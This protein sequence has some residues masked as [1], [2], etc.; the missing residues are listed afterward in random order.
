MLNF[1][2]V[3]DDDISAELLEECIFKYMKENDMPY[4]ITRF[5]EAVT[6]LSLY[7]RDFDIIFMDIM[8]PHMDGMEASKRLREVDPSVVLIFVTDMANYALCGYEVNAQD[9]IVK[10]VTYVDF[11]LKMSRALDQVNRVKGESLVIT[12]QKGMEVILINDLLYVEVLKHKV[13]YHLVNRQV[14]AYGALSKI[15]SKLDNKGF[16]KCSNS[17]IVNLKYITGICEGSEVVLDNGRA[18][19]PLTRSMKKNFTRALADYLGGTFNV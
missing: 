7:K 4:I 15:A 5:K 9:F 16:A 8:M 18:K 19:V 6:F 1:A 10:N 11:S 17:Y 3:D 12:T 14:T 2:I 13:T